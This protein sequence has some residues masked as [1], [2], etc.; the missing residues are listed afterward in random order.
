M[1]QTERHIRI[2][3]IVTASVVKV[4]DF[5]EKWPEVRYCV[6]ED[7]LTD[8]FCREVFRRVSA[9]AAKGKA[10]DPLSLMD[11]QEDTFSLL[12]LIDSYDF[13]TLKATYML[14][15]MIMRKP[16]IETTFGDYVRQ[17]ITNH[18]RR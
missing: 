9:S 13:D 6:T 18:E 16:Y 11:G 8:R 1:G 10:P 2:E 4:K 15:Q 14:D 3:R 7:M 17:L 5:A 12:K